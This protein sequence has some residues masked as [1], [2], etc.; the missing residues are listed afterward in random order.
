M[1]AD[2]PNTLARTREV[3]ARV[4]EC[5]AVHRIARCRAHQRRQHLEL[6]QIPDLHN[7]LLASRRQEVAAQQQT[8]SA[9]VS[10]PRE[11]TKENFIVKN[12]LLKT[13]HLM[14]YI[15]YPTKNIHHPISTLPSG[16]I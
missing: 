11:E 10:T 1:L 16:N 5:H 14:T 7:A 13:F 3:G 8:G 6:A 15:V 4:V 12:S 2:A 9:T